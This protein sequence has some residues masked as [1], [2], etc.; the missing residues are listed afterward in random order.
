M[1]VDLADAY[2]NIIP[3]TKRVG[4]VLAAMGVPVGEA[5]KKNSKKYSKNFRRGLRVGVAGAG[6]I[7]GVEL[8]R[9]I[10]DFIGSSV[11][12]WGQL[13]DH[14]QA[15][16]RVFG[17]NTSQYKRLIEM[18]KMATSEFGMSRKDFLDT[19]V[20]FGMMG[21]AIDLSDEKLF[22]FTKT[23][24]E[25][26]RDLASFRGTSVT[27][28][29]HA[30]GS[31]MRGENE[32]IRRYG[33][34]VDDAA[35]KTIAFNKGW[36]ASATATMSPAI[37]AK[38][39]MVALSKASKDAQGDWKRTMYDTNNITRQLDAEIQNLSTTLGYVLS[40]V[41]N[42][43][44]IALIG[45]AQGLVWV[46]E[47]LAAIYTLD[48]D[49][50]VLT[51]LGQVPLLSD[52]AGSGFHQMYLKAME[53]VEM[54]QGPFDA[55]MRVVNEQLL[56][57]FANL[58]ETIKTTFWSVGDSMAPVVGALVDELGPVLIEF[59][60]FMGPL[61]VQALVLM[62]NQLA[63]NIAALG[64]FAAFLGRV[65]PPAI[66]FLAPL[67][68]NTFY[69]I[70]NVITGVLNAV[71]GVIKVTTSV[72]RGDWSGAMQGLQAI[73]GG[74]WGVIKG[75]FSMSLS[76]VIS[77]V[78]RS[79]SR[80][81]G[82]GRNLT[83]ALINGI[84]GNIANAGAAVKS[85]LDQ[86]V[87]AVLAIGG[88]MYDSGRSIV[89]SLADG[90]R[91]KIGAA[92]SAIES[93]VSVISQYLPRSPAKRGPLSGRGYTLY[94]GQ[95]LAR[96]FARGIAGEEDQVR[97]AAHRMLQAASFK[98]PATPVSSRIARLEYNLGS[99][100]GEE[101]A[102]HVSVGSVTFENNENVQEFVDWLTSLPRLAQQGAM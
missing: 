32:P 27:D 99:T 9:G 41:I 102:I 28:A 1:G 73:A 55:A 6:A 20:S 46:L 71:Q 56:P 76:N 89:D 52:A 17:K 37:R 68:Q 59:Y 7:L 4:E 69:F 65:L 12:H 13:Q 64:T 83:Q 40:P 86:C 22:G 31:A 57:A 19:A 2:V 5:G 48:F 60:E 94:S 72:M 36:I 93:A 74:T 101:Q 82:G 49:K 66:R 47:R 92:A 98:T 58:W 88:R 95:A 43:A 8:S 29:V 38:A 61:F 77:I 75:I 24:L 51:D 18:N 53:F 33:V 80:M 42:A 50:T 97:G 62:V 39:V 85:G 79:A 35:L 91:S 84:K 67:V 21:R 63:S 16:G 81:L 90:I 70:K 54:L 26:S 10:T 78:L 45:L 96:D 23:L 34:Y 15:L 25:T 100:R 44:K 14:L 11:G 30:I 3:S 87:N